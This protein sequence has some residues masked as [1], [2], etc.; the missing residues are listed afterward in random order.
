MNFPELISMQET[1]KEKPLLFLFFD[2][3]FL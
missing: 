2:E 3:I 1:K